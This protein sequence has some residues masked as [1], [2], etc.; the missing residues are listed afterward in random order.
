MNFLEIVFWGGG[1]R[2]FRIR[3]CFFE[4][5]VKTCLVSIVL[6][7]Y[8]HLIIGGGLELPYN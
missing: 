6:S 1:E 8:L 5:N 7:L 2:K 4:K 3:R